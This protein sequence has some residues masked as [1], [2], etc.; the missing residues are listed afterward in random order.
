MAGEQVTIREWVKEGDR[1]MRAEFKAHKERTGTDTQGEQAEVKDATF[2]Q[3]KRLF[4]ICV[5]IA[6]MLLNLAPRLPGGSPGAGGWSD[7][8]DVGAIARLAAVAL[9]PMLTGCAN[10]RGES[11][12]P[13]LARTAEQGNA[14]AVGTIAANASPLG[15][16][17]WTTT[18]DESRVSSLQAVERLGSARQSEAM[19]QR[20]RREAAHG[21]GERSEGLLPDTPLRSSRTALNSLTDDAPAPGCRRSLVQRANLRLDRRRTRHGPG[22]CGSGMLSEAACVRPGQISTACQA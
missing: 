21:P 6:G 3:T 18:P 20:D 17:Q 2:A 12:D 13:A 5:V 4:G 16:A 9:A 7:R 11:L 8:G 19:P 15:C 22:H 1:A 10:L 14:E